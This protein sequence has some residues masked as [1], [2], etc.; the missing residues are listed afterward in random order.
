MACQEGE[1]G[2]HFCLLNFFLCAVVFPNALD[3]FNARLLL[4]CLRDQ[5]KRFV[6]SAGP[7]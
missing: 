1:T 2:R 7:R 5:M 4:A 3:C 6:V